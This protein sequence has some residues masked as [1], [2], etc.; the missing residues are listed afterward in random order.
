MEGAKDVVRGGAEAAALRLPSLL[1]PHEEQKVSLGGGRKGEKK[2]REMS[3]VKAQRN[4]SSLISKVKSVRKTFFG[5]SSGAI[6]IT[7]E[8]AVTRFRPQLS[9]NLP[10]S[11]LIGDQFHSFFPRG[12]GLKFLLR[13]CNG[14]VT[15]GCWTSPNMAAENSVHSSIRGSEVS[16]SQP[17]SHPEDFHLAFP[18]SC[19]LSHQIL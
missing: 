4:P 16:L 9:R 7:H 1:H 6:V 14:R 3:R 19:L 15:N 12:G 17:A 5:T 11:G 8:A 13:K 2:L 10:F 18:I